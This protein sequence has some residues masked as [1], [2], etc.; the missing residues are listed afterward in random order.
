MSRLHLGETHYPK[1][2]VCHSRRRK[3]LSTTQDWRLVTCGL[4]KRTRQYL[5]EKL[6]SYGCQPKILRHASFHHYG[7]RGIECTCGWRCMENGL[8]EDQ[9]K[10]RWLA[11]TPVGSPTEEE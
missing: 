5:T 8:T 10:I 1:Y 4:C 11:H 3:Q 9:L 7:Y 6:E 2:S